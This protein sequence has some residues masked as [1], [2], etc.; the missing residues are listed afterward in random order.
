MFYPGPVIPLSDKKVGGQ[1]DTERVDCVHK[2]RATRERLEKG[3]LK[4]ADMGSFDY[5]VFK[6][7]ERM[8]YEDHPEEKYGSR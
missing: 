1:I 2:Y 5:Q 4:L 6:I 8:Y 7:G 3:E